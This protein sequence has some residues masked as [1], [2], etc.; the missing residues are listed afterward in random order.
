MGTSP[1]ALAARASRSDALRALAA[2]MDAFEAAAQ[3]GDEHEAEL[4]DVFASEGKLSLGLRLAA[5]HDLPPPAVGED[6]T[7]KAAV[8]RVSAAL[9]QRLVG[10]AEAARALTASVAAAVAARQR[11]AD[12]SALG[13]PDDPSAPHEAAWRAAHRPMFLEGPHGTGRSTAARVVAHALGMRFVSYRLSAGSTAAS[14]LGEAEPSGRAPRL[15]VLARLLLAAGSS[16]AVVLLHSPEDA[17][18]EAQEALAELMEGVRAG[19]VVDPALDMPVPLSR[20]LVVVAC[21][22]TPGI[23]PPFASVAGRAVF[24]ALPPDDKQAVFRDYLLPEAMAAL[25]M[26]SGDIRLADGLVTALAA[27]AGTDAGSLG[28]RA[29]AEALAAETLRS[30]SEGS[31]LPVHFGEED[32]H[33]FL[34]SDDVYEDFLA[35]RLGSAADLDAESQRGSDVRG[36]GSSS[37]GSGGG[38][39]GIVPADRG[40]RAAAAAQSAPAGAAGG[41]AMWDRCGVL[42]SVSALDGGAG[43]VDLCEVVPMPLG[44]RGRR[45]S[46][47][48]MKGASQESADVALSAVVALLARS[49]PGDGLFPER[50][51]NASGGAPREVCRSNFLGGSAVEGSHCDLHRAASGGG[52]DARRRPAHPARPD[53]FSWGHADEDS[54]SEGFHAGSSAGGS[55]DGSADGL[56]SAEGGAGAWRAGQPSQLLAGGQAGYES[57]PLQR[58]LAHEWHTAFVEPSMRSSDGAS[59]GL[60]LA[61]GLLSAVLELPLPRRLAVTG[62][63]GLSGRV[64]QVGSIHEKTTAAALR[65]I[66]VLLLPEACRRD[67]AALPSQVSGK[68]RPVFVSTLEEAVRAVWGAE[69]AQ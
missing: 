64:M 15:G 36:G 63:M 54:E 53:R 20:A 21:D 59:G 52:R 45:L 16:D 58:L 42:A 13:P 5:L 12:P 67:F 57:G 2:S 31:A 7:P 35:D 8:A 43:D 40:E 28:L 56:A 3:P 49:R 22:S 62:S 25:G 26:S 50:C 27:K 60:C 30:V 55:A 18:D 37:G 48:A 29:C 32:L 34:S 38:G 47:T 1:G 4:S 14:I 11:L 66:S 41:G 65:G 61:L 46:V 51:W 69:E 23:D 9:R 24:R 39:V 17:S 10:Q 33:R 6:A 68:V 44:L 19:W